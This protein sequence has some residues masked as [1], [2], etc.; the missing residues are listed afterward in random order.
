MFKYFRQAHSELKHWFRKE[1]NE[2][3]VL[4]K[5]FVFIKKKE[6]KKERTGKNI[7]MSIF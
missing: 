4:R 1:E 3:D 5:A 2:L 7:V 6:R